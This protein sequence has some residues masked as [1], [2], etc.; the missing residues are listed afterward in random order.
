MSGILIRKHLECQLQLT[1][2]CEQIVGAI[3]RPTQ[4]P[5]ALGLRNMHSVV[6]QA[7]PS[8][9]RPV[10]VTKEAKR[11]ALESTVSLSGDVVTRT[12]NRGEDEAIDGQ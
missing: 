6:T 5:R 2:V 7:A 1:T 9:G 3:T 8:Y 12:C 11:E 10:L 4:K